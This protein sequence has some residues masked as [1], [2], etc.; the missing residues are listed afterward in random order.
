MQYPGK[1]SK[2][3]LMFIGYY[4]FLW[5]E[6]QENSPED[7]YLDFYKEKGERIKKNRKKLEYGDIWWL[8]M[9]YRN[10]VLE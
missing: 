9:I 5:K 8:N 7:I 2:F 6:I 10:V 3:L 4:D 1:S